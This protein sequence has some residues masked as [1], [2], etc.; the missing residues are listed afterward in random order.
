MQPALLE[1]QFSLL[2]AGTRL[3]ARLQTPVSTAVK[4]PIVAAIEYNYERDG[5]IVI[6]AGSKA[7]GELDQASD[8]GY[9]G[10]RFNSIQLPDGTSESIDGRAM[11]LNY[12]PLQGK[13]TGRNT[14][15]KFLVRS[16]TGVGEILAA[17][18]GTGGGL[19]VNDTISN[20]VLLRE[21]LADNVAVAGEQQM[22]ELA[23]RQNIVVT[24]SGN[25]R[26]YIVLGKPG[27]RG[28]RSAPGGS[29][30]ASNPNSP[31]YSAGST[32]SVQELREL[33]EL[34]NELTQ[35][36]QQ[37]QAKPQIAQTGVEQQ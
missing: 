3:V 10:I 6:P 17:T 25:T 33:L 11:G 31:S 16:L 22:N 21:R 35:M 26:F 8:Q 34:R 27:D 36:Y 23:Y 5:E 29:V 12:Q 15:K 4:T 7:F 13:V 32:P 18:V 28:A 37:Q 30:P 1:P 20:N 24:V 9:I 2:P 14:G 19:G